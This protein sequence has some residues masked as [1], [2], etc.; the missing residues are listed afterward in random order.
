MSSSSGTKVLHSG[1]G[2]DELLFGYDRFTRTR[3]ILMNENIDKGKVLSNIYYG[4]GLDRASEVDELTHGVSDKC[5]DT[6][7]WDWLSRHYSMWSN[8]VLQ[9]IFSQ[10][11]RL[12]SLLQRQDRGGM[13]NGVE[14]RV[15]FLA[16]EFVEYVNELPFHAKY[17][18]NQTKKI[19]RDVMNKR[20]PKRI[21]SKEKQGSP[22]F[23]SNFLE[24][25][26][27][28]SEILKMV[29]RKNGFCQSFLNG[30]KA[31]DMVHHHYLISRNHSTIMWMFLSLEV[32]QD[33]W[34]IK[35][36]AV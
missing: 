32:W 27:G 17:N 6:E 31:I 24:S 29:S 11:Y 5:E 8:D 34:I 28:Y 19:L 3:S 15:P 13:A 14:V 18:T 36:D 35:K 21:L 9:M 10:K 25:K 23:V 4:G 2:A 7:G 22:S 1:E 33:V 26:H 16:P 12:Q 30:K 20:L